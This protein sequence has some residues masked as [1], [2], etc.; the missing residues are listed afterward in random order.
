MSRRDRP[1]IATYE[2]SQV[3]IHIDVSAEGVTLSWS[4]GWGQIYAILGS[5]DLEHWD[6]VKTENWDDAIGGI[7]SAR[8]TQ[9][10]VENVEF[11]SFDT[12]YTFFKL[13]IKQ[14]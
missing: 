5:N 8:D 9:G 6:E 14:R 1:E 13:R 3:A 10:L 12:G 7:P 11:V 4:N 2:L